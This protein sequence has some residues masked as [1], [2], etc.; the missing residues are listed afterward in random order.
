MNI[1]PQLAPTPDRDRMPRMSSREIASLCD[2]RHSHV[3]RDIDVI[4]ADLE[5][6]ASRFGHIYL[7]SRNRSQTEYL[8]GKDL[9]LTLISGYNVILRKRIVD[10]WLELEDAARDR[11]ATIDLREPVQLARV[12]QQLVEINRDQAREIECAVL[13]NEQPEASLPGEIVPAADFYDYAD[14][15][16]DGSAELLIPAPLDPGVTEDLRSLAIRA[17]QAL[18]C[19]GLARVDF[20]YE[21]GGRGLLVN[22]INTMPGFTPISMYPKMWDATGVSYPE[23]ID[24]LVDLAIE[25]HQRRSAHR[26]TER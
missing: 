19:E 5:I 26:R 7:D 25:R 4:C 16:L 12:T 1:L 10:R 6:D 17:Y 21:E 23:L 24:R 8:L 15:Y 22:E 13:G 20:F 9:T 18:R 14:K 2:K 11:P 3:K